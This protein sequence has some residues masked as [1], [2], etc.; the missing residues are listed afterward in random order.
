MSLNNMSAIVT[1]AGRDI[2]RACALRLAAEG[3][4]VALSYH[5]SSEGAES[6]VT[7]IKANG[8]D[9]I[10]V[11]ADLNLSLIHI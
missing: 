2:G 8:G 9:A 11:Q 6:A 4:K 7:E 1:G 10:A 5:A 3:A